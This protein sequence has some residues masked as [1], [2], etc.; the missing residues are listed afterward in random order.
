M[1][2]AP[3]FPIIS[4][5]ANPAVNFPR[6]KCRFEPRG[7]ITSCPSCFVCAKGVG[8]VWNNLR[9][10]G[11]FAPLRQNKCCPLPCA[12]WGL[13][14]DGLRIVK[15]KDRSEFVFSPALFSDFQL[16]ARSRQNPFSFPKR[17][18]ATSGQGV[19]FFVDFTTVMFRCCAIHTGANKKK[20]R[21]PS[22][23]AWTLP[24]QCRIVEQHSSRPHFRARKRFRHF[25][26]T[27]F[28]ALHCFR[29]LL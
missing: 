12:W 27:H 2:P 11:N 15:T 26:V 1:L 23:V 25:S 20:P 24:E 19:L 7:V 18:L 21:V 13:R 9:N 6:A 10:T 22:F 5:A 14:R 4:F 17:E 29:P 28:R 3:A 8:W 16:K